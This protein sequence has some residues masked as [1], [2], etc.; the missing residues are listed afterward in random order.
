MKFAP[1]GLFIGIHFLLIP[2]G[3][4]LS[5][6]NKDVILDK[7]AISLLII[8]SLNLRKLLQDSN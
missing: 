3:L 7:L 2:I 6:Y 4:L 5:Y 8:V 1:K